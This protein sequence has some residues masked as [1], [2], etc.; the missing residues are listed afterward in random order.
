MESAPNAGEHL[1]ATGGYYR[2]PNG[3][4][5]QLL[6][7]NQANE[8]V[9]K[10]MTGR[11]V[12]ATRKLRLDQVLGCKLVP[13]DWTAEP[14]A[15]DPP[16]ASGFIPRPCWACGRFVALDNLKCSSCGWRICE[17]KACQSPDF[18]DGTKD[19]QPKCMEQAVRMGMQ[20]FQRLCIE[21]QTDSMS[22]SLR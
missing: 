13:T 14:K 7:I 1:P 16:A 21:R 11:D 5:C 4:V 17:C 18:W 2:M 12:G 3:I 20:R 10:F 6:E 15:H 8:Y 9:I 22:R 19:Y